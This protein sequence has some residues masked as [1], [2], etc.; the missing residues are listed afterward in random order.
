MPL[1]G[2]EPICQK[3]DCCPY[4]IGLVFKNM[5]LLSGQD[6]FQFLE[7]VWKPTELFEL[8]GSIDNGK[9][10]KFDL[11]WLKRFPSLVNSKYL[12][13]AFCLLCVFWSRMW[14]KFAHIR[15]LWQMFVNWV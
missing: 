2:D 7:N 3:E 14:S 15:V 4:E 12:D 6:K 8:L 10:R 11:S 1:A 13:G 9:S 5:I